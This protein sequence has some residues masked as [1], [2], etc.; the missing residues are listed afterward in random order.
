MTKLVGI[1]GFARAGKD[2]LAKA[3]VEMGYTRLAFADALKQ[4]TAFIADEDPQL[5]FDDVSKEELSP[6]LGI[7]RRKALQGLGNAVRE[8]LGDMT[9]V[10][11]VLRAWERDGRQNTAISDVRYP[12]EA[13]KI[14]RAGGIV[15]R[16]VR[17]G[18]GLTG[19]AAQHVSEAGIPDDLVTAET[20]NNGSVE[21]LFEHARD[22]DRRYTEL[23]AAHLAHLRFSA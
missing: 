9:W 18:A 13:V 16:V 22:I 21:D 2:T 14:L 3:L 20:L 23:R 12:N 7:P 4:A 6:T 5:Y 11:R 8:S 19:E 10:G 17:D 15:V 1:T